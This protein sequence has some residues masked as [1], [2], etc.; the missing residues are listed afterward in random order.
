MMASKEDIDIEK[1]SHKEDI[2]SHVS[3]GEVDAE[4]E[5]RYVPRKTG[6]IDAHQL[7]AGLCG[8]STL[9]SFLR[10]CSFTCYASWIARIL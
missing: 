9:G 1:Y 5:A 4:A 6:F 7:L 8:V 10:L 3:G 2:S